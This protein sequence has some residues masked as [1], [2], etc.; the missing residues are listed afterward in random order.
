METDFI[1]LV[2]HFLNL[3]NILDRIEYSK[4][5]IQFLKSCV[6]NS[7]KVEEVLRKHFVAY[8]KVY[9]VKPNLNYHSSIIRFSDFY[10][11]NYI[12][13]SPRLPNA[14]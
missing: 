10:T 2:R 13:Q 5:I 7:G 14:A 3:E 8:I 12:D 6:I 9:S 4:N 1:T 11:Q